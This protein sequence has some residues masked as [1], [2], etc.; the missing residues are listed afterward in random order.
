MK[1]R[2][3]FVPGNG[4]TIE[5]YPKTIEGLQDV[6]FEVHT[7]TPPWGGKFNETVS[8]TGKELARLICPGSIVLAHSFGT[9]VAMPE[10]TNHK[11]IGIILASPSYACAE[12]LDSPESLNY[13]RNRY[14]GQEDELRCVGMGRLAA[15][16]CARCETVSVLVGEREVGAYPFMGQIAQETARGFGI[17]A[18]VVPEAPHFID[19][20]K[21]YVN[22]V[23]EEASRI[24]NLLNP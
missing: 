16:A 1:D 22:K 6:G 19:Q 5:D 17:E 12:G 13:V 4:C 8:V 23:V 14:P 15:I 9:N 10:L 3:V 20:H 7:F 21:N 11:D 2:L 24:R 18:T